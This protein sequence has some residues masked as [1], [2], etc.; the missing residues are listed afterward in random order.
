AAYL[1]EP[2]RVTPAQMDRWCK[3]FDSWAVCDTVCFALFDRT[4]YAF[5]KV[6]AWAVR[7]EEWVKR[8]AFALL[9]G[10]AL[11]DKGPIEAELVKALPRCEAAA[12][13]GRNFV[14]KG[15]SWALRTIG[16]RD[17]A[18]H[19]KVTA[20]AA[21]LAKREDAASRWVG[22]D[23]LRDLDRPAIAERLA[24]KQAKA[25]AKQAKA[26]AKQAKQAKHAKAGAKPAK[27]GAKPARAGAKPAKATTKAR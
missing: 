16:A 17:H 22:K 20:L 23:V 21:E 24:A 8:A 13:D 27:A 14:K 6:H 4:P 5:D 12:T 1:D 25:E 18:L 7:E 15:V 9:A 10:V 3:Q 19:A 11:H 26:E 2:A